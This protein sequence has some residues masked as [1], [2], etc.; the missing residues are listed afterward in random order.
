VSAQSGWFSITL[1]TIPRIKGGELDASW[2]PLRVV[3]V[4]L[5]H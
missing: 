3:Y 4:T 1:P 5:N 2:R